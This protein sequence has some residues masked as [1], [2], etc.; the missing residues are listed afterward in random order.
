[1]TVPG[2]GFLLHNGGN[3]FSLDPTSPN[4]VA[5]RKRPFNTII[6]G[7]VT[8]DGS[9]L[10]AF[11]NMGGPVQA[12]A[13][14]QELVNVIDLGMNVQAAGDAAR[15]SHD[16]PTNVLQLEPALYDLVGSQLAAMGHTTKSGRGNDLGAGGYQAIYFARD[17]NAP[18]P[19]PHDH[20]TPV[21]GVYRAGSDHRKDGAAVGW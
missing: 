17:P 15:F 8:K 19:A 14:V 9:P 13:Q 10:L 1:V 16:Q 11:G 5:P 20:R 6:P 4:V 3:G 12:Q 7:F 21:N 18:T 2:Y